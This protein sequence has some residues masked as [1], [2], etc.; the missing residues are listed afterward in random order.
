MDSVGVGTF[1]KPLLVELSHTLEQFALAVEPGAPMIVIAM[2]QKLAYFAR[3]AEVYGEIAAR[4]AVTV[5]GLAEDAPPRLPPGVRHV[6]VPAEDDLEREWSV[7][8]LTP[9]GG[10]TLVAADL[11]TLDPAAPTLER[12]RTFRAGWSFRR[13]EARAQV[14]RL[15]TKLRLDDA[16]GAGIDAVLD[17]VALWPQPR[18]E[19]AWDRSVL[20]LADRMDDAIR[21]RATAAARLA[22]LE[23]GHD[24]DPHT[25]FYSEASLDRWI[26]GS[27]AGTL[28]VGLVLLRLPG[29][30]GLRPRY[31]RRGELAVLQGLATLLHDQ[32]GVCD[33]VVALG[34][35]EVLAVL[36]SAAPDDV[37]ALCHEVCRH[38]AGIG[39]AYPYVALPALVAGTVTR[40]RPLPLD[41]LRHNVAPAREL[42]LV[43]S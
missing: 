27:A 38:A 36:P 42:A 31:G 24:R 11:E 32:T 13:E 28:P 18:Q 25:G 21:T 33:R 15:R 20:F 3:E 39:D 6:L 10:A 14:H 1:G 30:A 2:F 19:A 16:T 41:R 17:A 7:T 23:D 8:A 12:G 35:E 22:A 9:G 34:P 29:L 37:L 4:G 5:V 43:P 26:A 40:A